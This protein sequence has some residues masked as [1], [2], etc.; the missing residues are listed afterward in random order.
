VVRV[1]LISE[2]TRR[3]RG[4]KNAPDEQQLSAIADTLLPGGLR[5]RSEEL[6]TVG[7]WVSCSIAVVD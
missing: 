6:A 5:L 2:A 3:V 1:L 7:F 4:C